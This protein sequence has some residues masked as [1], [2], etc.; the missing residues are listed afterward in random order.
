MYLFNEMHTNMEHIAVPHPP[1]FANW[2][3]FPPGEGIALRHPYKHQFIG[4][5]GKTDMHI[6]FTGSLLFRLCLGLGPGKSSH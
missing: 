5:R 4:Q 3:T 6:F 1:Q 2:G